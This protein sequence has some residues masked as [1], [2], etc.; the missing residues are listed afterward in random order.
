MKKK[1][2]VPTLTLGTKRYSLA[3]SSILAL[4]RELQEHKYAQ[5]S[6]L[7]MHKIASKIQLLGFEKPAKKLFDKLGEPIEGLYQDITDDKK[8][9]FIEAVT[10]YWQKGYDQQE[11]FKKARKAQKRAETLARIAET[12]RQQAQEKVKS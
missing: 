7:T 12:K 8:R 1:K 4:R 2:T 11:A 6:A 10:E 9:L 5:L 3:L